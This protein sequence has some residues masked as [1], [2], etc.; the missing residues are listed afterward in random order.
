MQINEEDF[1][2]QFQERLDALI[3]NM[4]A[5]PEIGLQEFY[6]MTC[7]LENLSFFSPVIYDLLQK[8]KQ[9]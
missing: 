3:Q 7:I 9:P 2:R 8:S 4:A 5:H 1:E 6:T